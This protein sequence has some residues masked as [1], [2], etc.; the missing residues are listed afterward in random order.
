[1]M[2]ILSLRNFA[3]SSSERLLRLTSLTEIEP[4]V[5]SSNPAITINNEVLPEPEGPTMPIASPD[6]ALTSTPRKILTA[7]ARLLSVK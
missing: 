7:P 6:L 4:D 5:T 1:M 2:P 3:N